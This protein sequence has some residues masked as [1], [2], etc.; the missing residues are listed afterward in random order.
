MLVKG[1]RLPVVCLIGAAVSFVN[2]TASLLA[3]VLLGP[4]RL[5]LTLMFKGRKHRPTKQEAS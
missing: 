2:P 4:I 1:L 3:F 5:V